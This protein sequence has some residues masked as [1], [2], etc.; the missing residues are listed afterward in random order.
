MSL[1]VTEEDFSLPRA[2]SSHCFK[3]DFILGME[4]LDPAGLRKRGSNREAFLQS[5]N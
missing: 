4:D 5:G 1:L 3:T 2:L